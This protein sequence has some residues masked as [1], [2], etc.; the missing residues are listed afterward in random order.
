MR[1][2]DGVHEL[3][4]W[5]LPRNAAP[6]KMQKELEAA[7]M[8]GNKIFNR[9]QPLKNSGQKYTIDDK[10]YNQYSEGFEAKELNEIELSDGRKYTRVQVKPR[11]G[12]SEV[13]FSNNETYQVGDFVWFE[14]APVIWYGD[15]EDDIAITKEIIMSGIPFNHVRDYQGDFSKTDMYSFMNNYLIKDMSF[16]T[17]N[18]FD[19]L[20]DKV[21][22]EVK[23]N[24]KR[25]PYSFNLDPVDE[26]EIIK[27]AIES[28]VAVYLHGRSSEGKSS[29]I[30]QLDP[31]CE[32]VY[33]VSA[34]IDSINGKSVYNQDTGEMID[35]PPTW[36]QRLEKKCKEEPDKIH[37]VF[38]DELANADRS[39]RKSIFNIILDK[40]VNGKWHLPSN[41]RIAAAGNELEDSSVAEELP[42]PLFNRFAHVYIHTPV[43]SWL[44]WAVTDN[45]EY[46][47]LDYH[48]EDR[49]YKIH[50]A[51]Y[52][53]I[54][55]CGESVLRSKYDG[56]KPNADPRKWEMA[57]KLLEKTNQPEMIRALVGEEITRD[58]V[59]FC[60]Q[61]VITLEDV[62]ADNYTDY[63][64][65]MDLGQKAA[66]VMG[67]STTS[68]E[69]LEKVRDFTM[70]LGPSYCAQFENLW[71]HG[72]ES[73]LE[74]IALLQMKDQEKGGARK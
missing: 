22:E 2:K 29:R 10:E 28:D 71:A 37:I 17:E 39:I 52:S 18:T 43:E 48:E 11:F 74:Q 60:N 40:E 32:I 67:L 51:I 53:F 73:R 9:G 57:S 49:K 23:T 21:E 30:K 25:N 35:I 1:G 13:T 56:K 7:Y 16:S 27:G 5:H 31:D 62:L 15:I 46:Q 61:E 47:R 59:N 55:Y 19:Y 8:K 34:S 64:L 65:E 3:T 58:F 38:F 72:D 20:V 12:S 66:T 42:E 26:E 63:D 6:K 50:P 44:S 14:K 69:N 4:C 45:S 33:L 24:R 68:K 41:A 54:S 36:F 70:R